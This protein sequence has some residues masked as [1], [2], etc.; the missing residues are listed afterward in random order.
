MSH[1]HL[2]MN[3]KYFGTIEINFTLLKCIIFVG[4]ITIKFITMYGIKFKLYYN[5]SLYSNT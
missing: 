2:C 1:R 5:Y 3:L 4:I